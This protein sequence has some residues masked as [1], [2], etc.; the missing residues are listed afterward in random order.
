MTHDVPYTKGAHQV[1]DG[2]WAYL[3]PDGG[4]GRSNAGLITSRDTDTSLL[5]D[6]LFD[7]EL[8]AE[9]LASLRQATP[10]AERITTVVNT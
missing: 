2:V 7:L 6:T 3:Q 4:W 8:T 5:V 1:A 10:A 9:M